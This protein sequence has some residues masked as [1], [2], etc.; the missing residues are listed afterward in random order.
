MKNNYCYESRLRYTNQSKRVRILEVIDSL[1]AGGAE[2]LLKNFVIEVKKHN[3]TEIEVC[4]L[5]SRNIFEE[6][7][8]NNGIKIHNLNL[9]FKYN[10]IGVFKLLNVIKRGNYDVVHVHLFPADIFVAIASLFLPKK[11]KYIFTE[12]SDYNR[13]RVCKLFKNLDCFTY[14]RYDKII[15]ISN[16]VKE[17]LV[18]WCA[19][20]AKK[21]IVIKNAIPINDDLNPIKDKIYDIISVGCLEKQKGGDILLRAIKI[22][23]EKYHRKL[24]VAIVGDGSLKEYLKNLALQYGINEYIDFLGVRKDVLELMRESSVFVLPSRWEGF[25]LVLLEAISVGVP[26]VATKVGGIPEIIEDGKD[27]ILVEPENPEGLA[28]TILRLLD[29]NGL[30]SSISLN[31]Y[32][33]VKGEYSIERYTK[34]LLNLYKEDI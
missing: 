8:S 10:P 28:N 7:L 19:L 30:R 31:A 15:C 16:K 4:T 9:G 25:G 26:V 13:R 6:E 3:D 1:Y 33:K 20:T 5:Y 22:L 2:S 11:I 27:G 18:S 12:H 14:S 32:K 17:A 34:D 24:K 29:D 21:T 23:K